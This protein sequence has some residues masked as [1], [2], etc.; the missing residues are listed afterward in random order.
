[1]NIIAVMQVIFAKGGIEC[2]TVT[3]TLHDSWKDMKAKDVDCRMFRW[4]KIEVVW[5]YENKGC[6]RVR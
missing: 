5:I 2:I 3:K 1:M 6:V 4:V